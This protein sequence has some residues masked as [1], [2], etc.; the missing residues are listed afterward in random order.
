MMCVSG[1]RT[2][3]SG[4]R[5]WLNLFRR[6]NSPRAD[7]PWLH[8]LLLWL[9]DMGLVSQ[10]FYVVCWWAPSWWDWT[11]ALVFYVMLLLT[12]SG[13]FLFSDVW[14][15]SGKSPD[16][17]PHSFMCLSSACCQP[18][19]SSADQKY[20]LFQWF[21]HWFRFS[22][23]LFVFILSSSLKLIKKNLRKKSAEQWTDWIETENL[24]LLSLKFLF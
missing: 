9:P 21:H 1:R 11:I 14:Q 24:I 6:G 22:D 19:T 7:G 17:W 10:V 5:C 20:L 16:L 12:C 18:I 2:V 8:L 4:T 15:E 3:W 23:I 13:L